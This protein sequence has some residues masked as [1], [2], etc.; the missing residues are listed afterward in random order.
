M[1]ITIA[2]VGRWRAGPERDLYDA[3]A[4]RLNWPVA[5]KEVDVKKPLATDV[6]IA[7]E[8]DLLRKAVAGCD[9]V[10]ALDEGGKTL[11]S[12]AFAQRFADWQLA[13]TAHAGFV[14]GGADGLDETARRQADLVLSLGAMTWPHMLVRVLLIEQIYRASSIL[15]GH[16]YHRA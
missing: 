15:A 12:R 6:R 1:K 3:Y 14:I 13:G 2:S 10:I 7:Q 16:P 8:A 11:A 5:L 4:R 9:V